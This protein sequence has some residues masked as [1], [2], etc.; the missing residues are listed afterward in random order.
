MVPAIPEVRGGC[1]QP[2]VY[3]RYNRRST[4]LTDTPFH[5]AF[6]YDT[7][8]SQTRE[9]GICHDRKYRYEYRTTPPRTQYEAGR[10]RRA[11]RRDAAGGL[12]VGKRSFP[13]LK[14]LPTNP[15]LH[16]FQYEKSKIY[17]RYYYGSELNLHP[18]R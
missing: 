18:M 1:T 15:R 8:K 9:R 16:Y 13:K 10:T 6:R 4:G 12:Q 5:F 11:A 14:K 7:I 17:W 2:S 3:N